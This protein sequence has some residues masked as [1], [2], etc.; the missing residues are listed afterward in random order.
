V[1]GF[2]LGFLLGALSYFTAHRFGS[3]PV[4]VGRP[5]IY[6]LPEGETVECKSSYIDDCG[7]HLR[8]CGKTAESFDCLWDVEMREK[9]DLGLPSGVQP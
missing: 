2:V 3:P 6:G 7:W 8:G 4:V 5:A 1:L 9:S